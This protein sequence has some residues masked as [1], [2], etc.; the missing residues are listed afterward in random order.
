MDYNKFLIFRYCINIHSITNDNIFDAADFSDEAKCIPNKAKNTINVYGAMTGY[1]AIQGN[2]MSSLVDPGVKSRI[3]L[4]DCKFGYLDFVSDVRNNLQC[5]SDFSM[6]TIESMDQY[7]Q[8]RKSSNAFSAGAAASATAGFW[9]IKGSASASYTRS[10]NSD[11]M[12][13]EKVLEKYKGEI[14][15]AKA[16]CLTHSVTISDIVRPVFTPDF[17]L[18]LED[19]DAA[20]RNPDEELKKAAVANFINEFGTHFAKETKLGAELIYERRF[21]N[22]GKSMQEKKERNECVRDEVAVSVGVESSTVNASAN[23][24]YDNKDCEGMKSGSD[25]SNNEG[26][27]AVKTISRGSRPINIKKWIDASFTPVAIKRKLDDISNLFKDEWMTKSVF[28]GF[29]RNLAGSDIK[30]MYN[31]YIEQYCSLILYGILDENCN[32]IGLLKQYFC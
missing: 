27:E 25:F 21:E 24:H 17:I 12:A 28:Y 19:M 4:H 32:V 10:S 2:P 8:E 22:K 15:R 26:F 16:T 14:T 23:A 9:G 1:D 18:H 7:E 31:K 6:K 11:Q 30:E 13:S 20:T 5:D 29:D 3:F